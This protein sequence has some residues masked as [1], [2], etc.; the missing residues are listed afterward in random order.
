MAVL[1]PSDHDLQQGECETAVLA[2]CGTSFTGNVTMMVKLISSF[3]C[4]TPTN[5][6][7]L[8]TCKPIISE[9]ICFSCY[10]GAPSQSIRIPI[11]NHMSAPSVEMKKS[12]QAI[13]IKQQIYKSLPLQTWQPPLNPKL[14][15]F[16]VCLP[17]TS[18]SNFTQFS[19]QQPANNNY[20]N[21]IPLNIS[22]QIHNDLQ[23]VLLKPRPEHIV[24]LK[25]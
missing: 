21:G 10:E 16:Q 20:T 4:I 24:P 6:N 17:P 25:I 22:I 3:P 19:S 14:A 7:N 12:V 5:Y 8:P 18:S 2:T 9:C 23:I 11:S 1:L 15:P 13:Q